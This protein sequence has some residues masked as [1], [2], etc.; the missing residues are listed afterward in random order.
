MRRYQP[1]PLVRTVLTGIVSG[2]V[3]TLLDVLVRHLGG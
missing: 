1:R 2:I 3:R